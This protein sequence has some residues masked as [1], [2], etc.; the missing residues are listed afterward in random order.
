MVQKKKVVRVNV[1]LLAPHTHAG[2]P[3]QPETVIQVRDDQADRLI[4]AKLAKP[5]ADDAKPV[6]VK[7]DG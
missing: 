6:N 2:I 7:K 5:A 4:E 3:Y 1:E